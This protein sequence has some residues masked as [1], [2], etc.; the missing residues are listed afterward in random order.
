[1]KRKTKEDVHYGGDMHSESFNIEIAHEDSSLLIC[2]LDS[3]GIIPEETICAIYNQLH[4]S[5]KSQLYP[6]L[7]SVSN[8]LGSICIHLH[9]AFLCHGS[10]NYRLQAQLIQLTQQLA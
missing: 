10:Q 5:F 8:K 1:M 4:F 7:W 2:M 9:G 6:D 3:N